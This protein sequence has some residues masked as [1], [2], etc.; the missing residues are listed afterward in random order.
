MN[1]REWLTTLAAAALVKPVAAER[2]ADTARQQPVSLDLKDFQPRSMLH[3]P[4]TEVP[5]ARF[6][7][8]DFHTHLGFSA[9]S[10][11]GVAQGEDVRFLALSKRE[12]LS[13]GRERA[14]C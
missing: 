8:I 13:R 10:T 7:V 1:R 11:G 6:P 4:E 14:L 9:A 2:Q 5:R 12:G 3:V